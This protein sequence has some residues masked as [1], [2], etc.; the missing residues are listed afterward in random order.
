MEAILFSKGVFLDVA[1][2]DRGDITWSPL[3]A[4]SHQWM[5]HEVTTSQQTLERIIDADLVISN[6]VVLDRLLLEACRDL[7][8]ICI[9]ATGTNNVDLEAANELGIAV[10]NVTGYA[11]A[12]VVQHVFS[13]ILSLVTRQ[14]QY[15]Q[16]VTRGDW[17]HATQF[18]LL[19]YPIW[20]L[21]GKCLGIVGY[22][23]LGRAVAQV[24]EAFAM[25]VLVA[26]RPDGVPES[27]RLM[28][29]ELLPKVDV[30]SLHMPLAKNTRNLIGARELDLMK[31]HALLINTARGGIVDES[32]LADALVNGDLGGAGVDVLSTE[33][34][35][36]DNP[37]LNPNVPNLIVTPHIAWASLQ[38]RQRLVDSVAAN[39]QAFQA[40]EFRNRVT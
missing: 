25:K 9:A 2:V 22:G 1:S 6:K 8:L 17:Q 27:G 21:S 3:K 11:T 26:Q 14:Q 36:D 13:L 12:S 20:E 29:D 40:G 5:W 15:Q 39:I 18:C 37:L 34:P 38:A 24:A 31:S 10:T 7:K 23:E 35:T 28:L 19:N 33:P 16:A 30:L 32:A 4:F